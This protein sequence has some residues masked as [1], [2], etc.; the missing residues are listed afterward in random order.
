MRSIF[1]VYIFVFLLLPASLDAEPC[2][3][4]G[5][6][7][8]DEGAG[9]AAAGVADMP[10]VA[11]EH[12]LVACEDANS[13]YARQVGQVL[14]S[15]YKQ[16]SS[17]FRHLDLDIHLPQE[18][19]VWICF[20]EPGS[21]GEYSLS[22]DRMDLSFMSGYY[23]SR[24]NRV[25]ILED[26]PRLS[27]GAALIQKTDYEPALQSHPLMGTAPN[28]EEYTLITKI[29]HELGHQLAFNSGLQKR[30]VMYPIWVSEGVAAAFEEI[31]YPAQ[32]L[33]GRNSVRLGT[34]ARMDRHDRLIG[35]EEFV[36]MTR[37]L[38]GGQTEQEVY[39]QSWGLFYFLS[40][41]RKS[42]L[43]EY[44]QKLDSCA[45]GRRSRETLEEEFTASFGP[46]SELEGPWN[47]FLRNLIPAPES[48]TAAITPDPLTF[49]TE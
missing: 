7:A 34:L 23:S 4:Q 1:W 9:D 39:A 40:Q 11:T 15:A 13:T 14:E 44:L 8:A 36:L 22:S 41:H 2:P 48:K 5:A 42:N 38:A 46:V 31:L 6:E 37:V 17:A 32:Y 24:T 20:R 12:F 33:G 49:T 47:A 30:R 21:F 35:L 16:F 19:L 18:K 29:T 3:A 10:R 25:A 45:P 26:G 28:T 27:H 43:K